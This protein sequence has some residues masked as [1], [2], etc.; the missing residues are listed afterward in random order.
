MKTNPLQEQVGG[1]HYKTLA[2]QPIE[3]CQ[4]NRLTACE[5]NVVKYLCR[6]RHKNGRQ[7]IE[8]ALHYLRLLLQFEYPES[9]PRSRS[10]APNNDDPPGRL[11]LPGGSCHTPAPCV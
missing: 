7:D 2:I 3:F 8:K 10:P 5:T 1:D 6:H 11:S 9:P 4:R